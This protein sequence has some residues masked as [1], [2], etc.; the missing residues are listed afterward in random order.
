VPAY[1]PTSMPSSTTSYFGVDHVMAL[2]RFVW[3][4][5]P[6]LSTRVPGPTTRPAATPV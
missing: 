1:A 5:S 2:L 3:V 4:H 6:L